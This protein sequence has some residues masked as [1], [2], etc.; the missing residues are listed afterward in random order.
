MKEFDGRLNLAWWA[1]RIGLGLGPILAGIDKYF[2][3][4][5]DWTMYLNPLATKVIPV[6]AS[7]FM[8]VVGVVEIIAGVI[9]L[10]R[11]TK[12]GSYIVMAWLLAIAVNLVTMGM[13]FDLAVRDVEI[14]IGAFT[15]AQ[16]TAVREHSSM[17]S[18][19]AERPDSR[20]AFSQ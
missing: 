2:N 12:I 16:L 7:T 8:H 15:L 9:V 10:S 18:A 4:L 5:A 13:F 17:K 6:S 3:I 20:V 14:A 1:L 19:A 11:W